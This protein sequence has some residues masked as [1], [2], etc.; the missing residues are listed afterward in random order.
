M[1][2]GAKTIEIATYIA[3]SIDGNGYISILKMMTSIKL[4]IGPYA[5]SFTKNMDDRHILSTERN[6]TP[7]ARAD[8][9]KQ[10]SEEIQ[11]KLLFEE[12]ESTL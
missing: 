2:C 11:Q 6:M 4:T 10:R 1:H 9:L 8:I 3:V 5:Y 7:S 12:E